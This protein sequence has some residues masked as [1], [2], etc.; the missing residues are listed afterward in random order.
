MLRVLGWLAWLGH[1][2]LATLFLAAA[3]VGT[4]RPP[5]AATVVLAASVAALVPT[6]VMMVHLGRD[7]DLREDDRSSWRML[8]FWAGPVA[9][10]AYLTRRERRIGGSHLVRMLRIFLG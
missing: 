10:A 5:G 1:G 2:M 7:Q 4:T 8:L 6:I 9:A 3:V